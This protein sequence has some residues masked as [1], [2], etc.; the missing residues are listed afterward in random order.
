[1]TVRV[2]RC[3]CCGLLV[4]SCGKAAEAKQKAEAR[5]RRVALLRR[6][7][8]FQSSFP[9][10][11]ARCSEWFEVGTPIRRDKVKGWLAECCSEGN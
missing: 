8:W 9:G 2:E 5:A 11:C 7:G 6:P 4:E 10:S 3:E 1:M